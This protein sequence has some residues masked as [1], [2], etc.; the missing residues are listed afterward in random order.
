MS[1]PFLP[2]GRQSIDDADI[3]AVV[4]VLRG[5][6]LTTGPAVDAFE[7]SLV[8]ET[9]AKHAVSCA[10]GTAALHLAALALGLKVGDTVIVPAVTFLATANA[11]IFTGADVVFADVDPATGLMRASDLE[12]AIA[13][14]RSLGKIV[15]AVFNVHLA[16]QCENLEEIAMVADKAGARVVEDAAHAVGGTW[17]DARVG[18]G[19][20]SMMTT[21][22]FHPVKTITAGEG[23]AVT[24][25]DDGLH[26]RLKQMRNHG[27]IREPDQFVDR[28]AGFEDGAP[29]PWYYEMHEPGLNYRLSDIH[30]A[31][32]LSQLGKIGQFI[33]R[34]RDLVQAYDERIAELAPRVRALGRVADGQPAWHLYVALIDFAACGYL[35][36]TVM[37]ALHARGIGTQVHYI[38]LPFQPFYRAREQGAIYPGAQSYYDRCL[39]L[40]LHPAMTRSD[41]DR[42]VDEMTKVLGP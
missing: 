22:S 33:A 42:V 35:R 24:T 31:L 36:A 11:V 4:E 39:S 29:N 40:P 27:M 18:D 5:D 32:A 17:R 25:N 26:R 28:A 19:R 14:A 6:Y 12:A 8:R 10:N 38:P 23:G 30:A 15:K 16:G 13:R 7:Q 20:Y 21:M 2:Y 3:A 41:V 34:R 9:G 1:D 37:R